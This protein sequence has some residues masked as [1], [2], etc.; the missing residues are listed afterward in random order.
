MVPSTI[1]ARASRIDRHPSLTRQELTR[2]TEMTFKGNF[3]PN[4]FIASNHPTQTRNLIAEI[5]RKQHQYHLVSLGSAHS[6]ELPPSRV[7]YRG[8]H[9]LGSRQNRGE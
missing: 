2:D 7:A 5:L 3:N 1:A 8:C 4:R 9:V 6:Q